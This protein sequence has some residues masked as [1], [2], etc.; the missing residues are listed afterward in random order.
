MSNYTKILEREES[1]TD[2][3]FVGE[4]DLPHSHYTPS[5]LPQKPTPQ[6]YLC[7]QTCVQL[8]L[9]AHET[10]GTGQLRSHEKWG[11]WK[12]KGATFLPM[13]AHLIPPLSTWQAAWKEKA[14][15]NH[16]FI[17]LSFLQKH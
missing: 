8:N 2:D 3:F 7:G 6:Y 5:T 4:E 9:M 12:Q 15:D 11:H 13:S 17:F 10:T 16:L 1:N 14:L